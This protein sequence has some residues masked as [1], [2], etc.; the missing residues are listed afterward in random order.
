VEGGCGGGNDN[1]VN[2]L[3]TSL[4]QKSY[5]VDNWVL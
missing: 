3:L 1:D 2:K 4:W 5:A